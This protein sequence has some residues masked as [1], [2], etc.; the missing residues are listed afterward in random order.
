MPFSQTRTFG[1]E[2]ECYIPETKTKAKLAEFVRRSARVTCRLESYSHATPTFWKIVTDGSLGYDYG[3]EIVSP[4]LAGDE[5]IAALGR[6]M[7]AVQ[8]FGCKV[9]VQCGLHVHVYAGDCRIDEIKRIAINFFHFEHFFDHIMPPSRR[10][11]LNTY[12][13]SNRSIYG[14]YGPEAVNRA[15]RAI[16]RCRDLSQIFRATCE[17]TRY[18][19]LNLMPLIGGEGRRATST[20]EFR[21]HSGTV[22]AEKAAQWAKLCVSFVEASRTSKPRQRKSETNPSPASEMGLFFRMFKIDA[23]VAEFYRARRRQLYAE[24]DGRRAKRLRDE[25]V[26]REVARLRGQRVYLNATDDSLRRVAEATIIQN[27]TQR[28]QELVTQ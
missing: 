19:K 3:V 17:T 4:P 20:I 18:R 23:E 13:T 12:V 1:V 7:K 22:E 2:I 5:G 28:Q 21:Q 24:V 26:A 14:G 10:A 6:V 11:S 9:N 8:E 16:H 27:A 15:I 25:A